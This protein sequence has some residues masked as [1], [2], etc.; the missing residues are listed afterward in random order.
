MRTATPSR[1][2][3]M[4]R[5]DKESRL[6]DFIG[7]AMT[8]SRTPLAHGVSLTLFV[9]SPDSPVARA[10]H[11]A[12]SEGRV[13]AA[14]I[15]IVICDTNMEDATAPS[16]L[17]MTDADVRVLADPSFGPAH[18]Q[19]VVGPAHVWIGDCLR[20]DPTKRDAFELYHPGDASIGVFAAASFEK[21]WS[22]GRPL[23]LPRLSPEIIAAQSDDPA[24][25]PLP[26]PR[27]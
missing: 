9:R 18:E 22:R 8:A 15:R 17:D 13:E 7:E 4:S 1:L 10:L 11:S 27:H 19:L 16:L 21:L 3:T 14:H 20:R 6:K 26:L 2:M 12:W 5:T 25:L 23:K 24:A